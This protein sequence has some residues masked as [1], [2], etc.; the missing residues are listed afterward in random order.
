MSTPEFT[1]RNLLKPVAAG[2]AGARI[3]LGVLCRIA[4]VSG[5][6]SPI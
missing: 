3:N 2:A 6:R 4:V 5:A 1:R